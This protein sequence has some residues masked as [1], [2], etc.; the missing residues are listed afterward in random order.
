MN[1]S[2]NHINLLIVVILLGFIAA[3]CA[4]SLGTD[5]VETQTIQSVVPTKPIT[6][7]VPLKTTPT[8]IVPFNTDMSCWQMKPLHAG[9]DIK[10]SLLFNYGL[11]GFF[12]WD[13]SSFHAKNFADTKT[14]WG[15]PPSGYLPPDRSFILVKISENEIMRKTPESTLTPFTIPSGEFD[16]VQLLNGRILF[17]PY[18]SQLVPP[19][20]NEI[21]QKGVGYTDT[22]YIY[23]QKTGKQ[24]ENHSVF[25]PKFTYIFEPRAYFAEISYS[26]EGNYVLYRSTMLEGNDGYSLMDLRSSQVKWTL[27]ESNKVIGKA[28]IHP[29]LPTW[30][31]DGNSL[32]GIWASNNGIKAPNFY[33][34]S[35]DGAITQFTR[36][37]EVLQPGYILSFNP[38]WSPDNRYMAFKVIKP[39]HRSELELF[40][41]DSLSNTLLNPC[42]PVSGMDSN[43]SYGI[44][45]SFDSEHIILGLP[46]PDMP[47]FRYRHLLLDIPNRIIYELP[48]DEEMRNYLK[49]S[50]EISQYSDGYWMNWEIP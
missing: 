24:I 46:F 2:Q 4:T 8:Q 21:Y 50:G 12:F 17:A 10:G 6:A 13:V 42:L 27:P 19:V 23:D 36:L 20:D 34:I 37:E 28:D 16:S 11:S 45:W 44:D 29:Y 40:I 41:W 35:L 30:K 14:Y 48:N 43:S 33:N 7:T 31:P 9:T 25:L 49:L 32:T 26:P 22:Y 38:D 3:S 15:Y 1:V 5:P 47:T 18:G 39:E